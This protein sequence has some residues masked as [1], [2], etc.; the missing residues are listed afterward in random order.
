MPLTKPPRPIPSRK[1]GAFGGAAAT[2]CP[3]AVR[4]ATAPAL[5]GAQG[6]HSGGGARRVGGRRVLALAPAVLALDVV[7][8]VHHVVARA[9]GDAQEVAHR[10]DLLDLLLDEPLHELL[11]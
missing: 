2:G 10:R 9:L 5:P 4:T 3:A 11:A 1:P 6:P 7:L 8:D